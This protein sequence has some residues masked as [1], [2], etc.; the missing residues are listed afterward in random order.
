[1][2]ERRTERGQGVLELV[3][4]LPVLLV[5]LFG[6]VEMGYALRNYLVVVNADREGCRF[7]ARGRFSDE[8]AGA[9]VVSAGGVVSLGDPPTNVPFLRTDI[10][11]TDPNT[12]IIVTQIVLDDSG[13]V[14]SYTKWYSGVVPNGAG[15]VQGIVEGDSRVTQA[16]I[17][18]R[19]TTVTND[20]NG[21]RAALGY[22][23][24]DNH[25]V[26]VE[27]FFMHHPLWNSP[28][29]PLPDPWMMYAQTEMRVITERGG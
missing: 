4:M 8:L 28:F 19:H 21:T 3:V 10:D 15:G 2:G 24:M 11:S 9:R 17:E 20:I 26:V 23:R 5:L 18:A 7:A 1:M 12:G 29:V 27:I 25:I 22:E 14:I 16:Q 6:V 13:A